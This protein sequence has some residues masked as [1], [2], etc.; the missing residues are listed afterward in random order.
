MN[1]WNNSSHNTG[2]N[3]F[4]FKFSLRLLGQ[5]TKNTDTEY[6]DSFF[7]KAM[8]I[9][10]I[11]ESIDASLNLLV[12]PQKALWNIFKLLS[13]ALNLNT[14]SNLSCFANDLLSIE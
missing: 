2:N 3:N 6:H 7:M 4:Q 1:L 5:L 14:T 11:H 9:K 10:G 8:I 13:S 12:F